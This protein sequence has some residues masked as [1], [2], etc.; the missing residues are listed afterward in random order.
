MI[1]R[2]IDKLFNLLKLLYIRNEIWRESV[3]TETW[4]LGLIMLLWY[5]FYFYG[6]C[7]IPFYGIS[8]GSFNVFYYSS[9]VLVVIF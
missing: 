5:L 7:T 3:A 1:P 9:F 4:K 2:E 6:I 8:L